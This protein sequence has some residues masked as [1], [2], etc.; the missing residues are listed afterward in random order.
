M[1]W[2]ADS[3]VHA[4]IFYEPCWCGRGGVRGDTSIGHGVRGG[5]RGGVVLMAVYVVFMV[6]GSVVVAVVGTMTS[7]IVAAAFVFPNDDDLCR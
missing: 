5:V 3:C 7:S 4:S 1:S 2:A 6:V